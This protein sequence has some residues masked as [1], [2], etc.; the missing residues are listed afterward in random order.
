MPA[1]SMVARQQ[2]G[3]R[4][5]TALLIAG[6]V[7]APPVSA[8]T[9]ACQSLPVGLQV[10]GSGGPELD[11]NRAS[12]GY[13]LWHH[14][15]ARVLI[16][17]GPGSMLRFD[18]S[19]AR[20]EDL[21]VILLTHLHVDHSGDLPALLKGS[22]FSART[23]ELPLFGPSGS[24]RFPATRDFVKALF[25]SQGG[26]FR[27]LG[28]YLSG[29]ESFRLV[30]H[31][32]PAVGEKPVTVLDDKRFRITAI[33]VQHGPVPALAWRVDL[34]G[35]SVAIS[36][37]MNGN[38]HTLEILANGA[39]VLIAHH[40]I[41]EGATGVER[42]LHMPPSVIGRIAGTAKVKRLVL[43]HRMNRTLGHE[44]ESLRLIRQTYKG[45]VDLADDS[46]CFA[47]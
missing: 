46:Q 3:I 45:P 32:L 7:L 26:A 30:A 33:P 47:P 24:S 14:G 23:A 11:D 34:A 9:V 44:A 27:Y 42:Q 13:L 43:S 38:D 31:D 6:F 20:L 19:G 41:P 35:R 1:H 15:K 5:L 40:A 21:E 8:D 4:Y 10:L 22:F 36:G 16:D 2:I 28:D 29:E 18:Q 12:T 17:I 39:D 37:D 25:G